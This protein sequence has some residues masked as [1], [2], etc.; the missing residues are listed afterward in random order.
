MTLKES[1]NSTN[2]IVDGREEFRTQQDI[3]QTD[4]QVRE[5]S[6]PVKGE[7]PAEALVRDTKLLEAQER[8]RKLRED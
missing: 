3:Q 2:A 4:L 5:L 1:D 7:T 8:L 6:E